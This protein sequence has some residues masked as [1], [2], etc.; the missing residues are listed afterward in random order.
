MKFLQLV[1]NAVGLKRDS[2]RMQ[3]EPSPYK[4]NLTV[5]TL[6]KSTYILIENI[7]SPRL[8]TVML[9]LSKGNI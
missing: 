4:Y 6:P 1:S 9:S 7:Y 2:E 5:A 8:V 3:A